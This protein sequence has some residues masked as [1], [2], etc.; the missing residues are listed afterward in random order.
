MAFKD[1]Y[2]DYK[3]RKEAQR[4]FRSN[5]DQFLDSSQWMKV[6][7]YGIVSCIGIGVVLGLV[8]YYAP[9]TSVWFYI[10]TGYLVAIA[11]T[12][13]AN[14]Q[15]HQAGYA[16]VAFTFLSYLISIMTMYSLSYI[17]LGVNVGIL[18]FLSLFFPSLKYMFTGSVISIILM[19]VG[20]Y[21][22]YM[23]AK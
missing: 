4:Y 2:E 10:I 5:N 20:L 3:Q 17:S 7:L 16:A 15:C 1:K 21:E 11:I 14:V 23:V 18:G 6:I 22:A 8:I 19:L 9:I 13:A 12:K